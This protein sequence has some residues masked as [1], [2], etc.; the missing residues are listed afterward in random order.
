M[1]PEQPCAY[2]TYAASL[3]ARQLLQTRRALACRGWGARR[4]A[5]L[6]GAPVGV[7]QHQAVAA[8]E[9]EAAAAG[10]GRQQEHELA[11]GR[12]IEQLDQLLALADGRAAV[13]LQHRVLPGSTPL[14][15]QASNRTLS[16]VVDQL[17]PGWALI[18]A[19]A[20]TPHGII[21]L[22]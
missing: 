14:L 12:V 15:D 4:T 20:A 7:K 11:L 19:G 1:L 16:G 5:E 18:D 9:V 22:Q 2:A 3:T 8:D 10:L 6:Q 17:Y 21:T 13:Q